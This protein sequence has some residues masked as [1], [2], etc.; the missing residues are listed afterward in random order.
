MHDQAD[1][2]RRL[3]LGEEAQGLAPAAPAPPLVT[4]LGGKGGV[5]TTTIAV[6]LA[7]A[8]A[9]HGRR[10]VLVDANLQQPDIATQC[11]LEDKDTLSDVLDGRRTVHEVLQRGP[12]GIQVLPGAWAPNR[13]AECSEPAQKR[14]L[15]ELARLGPHTDMVVLDGGCGLN[16]T[17]RRF[18]QASDLLLMVTTGE[19]VSIMDCY[20]T[21]KSLSGD[22]ALS[23]AP[24]LPP[25]QT[26][27]NQSSDE[28]AD[29]DVHDRIAQ[30][31]RRFLGLE[32]Q[33]VATVPSDASVAS[34]IDQQAPLMVSNK[35]SSAAQQIDRLGQHLVAFYG[36]Y[37]SIT[38][39]SRPWKM[40]S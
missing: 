28:K 14:L 20:A 26:V 22:P 33:K 7:V 15:K 29:D 34:A 6:N 8:I 3:V 32:I 39:Q 36:Q 13:V 23:D 37:K 5:G 11:R 19:S 2:L 1:R 38:N 24:S 25:I 12:A 4:V 18:A 31:C 17:A 9:R 40:A 10:V 16:P 21:I 27:V 35:N 30:A